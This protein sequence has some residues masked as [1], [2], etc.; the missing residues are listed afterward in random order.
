MKNKRINNKIIKLWN[1]YFKDDK[2]V[3]GP[4]F[5]DSFKADT[6]LFVGVN[7]SF[8]ARGFKSILKD[9]EYAKIDPE[10][11][12]KWSNISKNLDLVDD[13]INVENYAYKNY[14]SYFARP[15][16]IAKSVGID[17]QHIDLFLYKETNQ[18]SFM[19]RILDK[20]KLNQFGLD[21]LAIFEDALRA[22]SPKAIVITNAFGS[23]IFRTYFAD[24]LTWDDK[25][26]HHRF[27]R[28]NEKVPIFFSSMLS[29]Q[30]ALD[31]W[32]YERLKWHI[33]QAVK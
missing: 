28:G 18:S 8:S 29:G 30:R 21:Q 24:S 6:L 33:G 19:N 12:F 23:E 26:G 15:A 7:P 5:Y 32:S 2:E 14:S 27:K 9:T 22:V 3:Y 17:W 13:C 31:R 10:K 20:G 1:N 16:E 11:F 25:K 4:L